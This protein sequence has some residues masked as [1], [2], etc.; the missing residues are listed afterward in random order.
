MRTSGTGTSTS[1]ACRAPRGFTLI[2]ILVVLL[3][4]GIMI[5]GAVLATGVAHG[6]RDLERERDRILALTGYLRDQATLQ[7]REFGLRC[8][9]GGYEF[10]A[11]DARS[12][13]WKR[14]TG[15]ETMRPRQL[16]AGL[17]IE[18]AIEG[19][20]IVLPKADVKADELAPQILL[21]SSG[22][23]SLFDLTLRRQPDGPGLRFAPAA[24]SDQIEVN[25]VAAG[26]A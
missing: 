5:A 1:S 2:E 7:N 19:R 20:R 18:L 10:L 17:G 9:Q 12:G 14:E 25:A 15:D 13:L 24:T 8:Y 11:W 16:P 21:Y 23:L 4:I 22:E 6:D 26:R 3:I